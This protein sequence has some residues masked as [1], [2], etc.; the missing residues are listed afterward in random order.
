MLYDLKSL[1]LQA[2]VFGVAGAIA[3]VIAGSLFLSVR[4]LW[5]E[6]R[7]FVWTWRS[8]GLR[9]ALRYLPFGNLRGYY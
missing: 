6:L 8:A 3:L 4:W 1:V 2:L 5:S 7:A 9:T